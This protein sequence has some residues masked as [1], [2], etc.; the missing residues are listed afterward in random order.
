MNIFNI[1]T[2][3]EINS[4]RS[5]Y[6]IGHKIKIKGS[7]SEWEIDDYNPVIPYQV[8]IKHWMKGVG[9]SI[10]NVDIREVEGFFDL[11]KPEVVVSS[12]HGRVV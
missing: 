9:T 5:V 7:E 11:T 10:L 12:E 1:R 3:Q 6:F 4:F 2:L 8:R